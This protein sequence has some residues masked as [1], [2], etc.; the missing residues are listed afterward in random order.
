MNLTLLVQAWRKDAE[1]EHDRGKQCVIENHIRE[2]AATLN[3]ATSVSVVVA[4]WRSKVYAQHGKR[5]SEV[6]LR[7]CDEIEETLGVDQAESMR[8]A[9]KTIWNLSWQGSGSDDEI[10]ERVEG[11]AAAALGIKPAS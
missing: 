2:L 7:L 3:T 9:L 10:L 1:Q 11:V 8:S 4:K 5:T 6:I